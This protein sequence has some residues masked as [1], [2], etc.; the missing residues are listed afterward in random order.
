MP[1][2]SGIFDALRPSAYNLPRLRE[3]VAT[4]FGPDFVDFNEVTGEF[5]GSKLFRVYL[6]SID[7]NA[8]RELESVV[9][10][11]NPDLLTAEQ[12]EAA[13]RVGAEAALGQ[14][15]FIALRTS[16]QNAA[17][18]AALRPI[19]LAM[20]RIMYRLAAAQG[21]TPQDEP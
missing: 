2:W 15:D 4:R 1:E 11:H 8:R 13:R 12:N 16:I 17:T 21:A 10:A 6:R 5:T 9:A 7:A 3:E 19:L 18:L 14:E 20:L